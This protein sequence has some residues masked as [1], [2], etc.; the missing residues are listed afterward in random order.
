M[1]KGAG[2]GKNNRQ[3]LSEREEGDGERER[4]SLATVWRQ[5]VFNLPLFVHQPPQ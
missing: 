5:R 1:I 4:E 3:T 2:T